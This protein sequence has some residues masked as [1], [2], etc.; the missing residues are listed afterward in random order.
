[1]EEQRLSRSYLET[2]STDDLAHLARRLGL[3]LPEDLNR[4]FILEEL[5][6]ASLDEEVEEDE[7]ALADGAHPNPEEPLP[8]SYNETFI[9]VLLRDPV[10]AYAFWEI[11][12][13]DRDAYEQDPAFAGYALRVTYP[14][15]SKGGAE[16]APFTIPVSKADSAWYL[17]LPGGSG[18]FRVE[19]LC[20]R[21]EREERL[22]VSAPFK[23]PRGAP[24]PEIFEAKGDAPPLYTLSG[25][26]E[27]KVLQGGDRESRLP[28]RCDA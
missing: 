18:W 15:V 5:L 24:S 17:C 21:G 2:L 25:L 20:K 6:D 27:L 9:G 12:Q 1:M 19:L 13:S 28:Q 23:V 8:A 11:R 10:W 14:T 4:V 22:A 3:D 16:S 7:D 26:D